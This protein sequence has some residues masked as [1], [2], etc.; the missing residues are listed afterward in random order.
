M[1]VESPECIFHESRSYGYQS[2][3]V[4]PLEKTILSLNQYIGECVLEVVVEERVFKRII[5]NIV[6]S[7]LPSFK[8]S[9]GSFLCVRF[10]LW[11]LI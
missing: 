4:S 1:S 9:T 3:K 8:F 6:I 11:L 10:R 2:I 7:L 5:I